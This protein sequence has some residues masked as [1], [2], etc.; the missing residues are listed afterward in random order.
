V[1]LQHRAFALVQSAFFVCGV[2]TDNVCLLF[3]CRWRL[4]VIDT[5]DSSL[6][7]QGWL[8]DVSKVRTLERRREIERSIHMG[9]VRL[10][11]R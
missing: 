11:M 4:H 9:P 8:E 6:S 3:V 7:A 10:Q 1:V 2:V 5:D